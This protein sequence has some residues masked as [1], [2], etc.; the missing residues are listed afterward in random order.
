MWAKTRNMIIF[1]A[2]SD[3]LE[4]FSHKMAKFWNL[5]PI[6]RNITFLQCVICYKLI[7]NNKYVLE[8]D[9]KEST[10]TILNQSNLISLVWKDTCFRWYSD[11]QRHYFVIFNCFFCSFAPFRLKFESHSYMLKINTFFQSNFLSLVDLKPRDW[12]LVSRLTLMF[13]ITFS[14]I[15]VLYGFQIFCNTF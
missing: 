15:I 5:D 8:L 12:P 6:F 1:P 2:N 9:T 11:S 7:V 10:G 4:S 3:N 13:L 14:W